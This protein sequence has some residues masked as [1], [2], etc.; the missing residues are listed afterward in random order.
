ML[1]GGQLLERVKLGP[2][3]THACASVPDLPIRWVSTVCPAPIATAVV[4]ILGLLGAV[5]ALVALWTLRERGG[6]RP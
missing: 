4:G 5:L 2:T 3:R 6:G 1:P